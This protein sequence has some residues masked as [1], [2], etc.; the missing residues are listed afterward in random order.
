MTEAE[1]PFGLYVHVPFCEAKCSYCH[2]RGLL[3]S[4]EVFQA[5]V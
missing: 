2:S 4:H 5:F 1:P 3:V